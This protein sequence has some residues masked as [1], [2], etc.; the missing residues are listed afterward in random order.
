ML[1]HG[2][3]N[4]FI[5]WYWFVDSHGRR[6]AGPLNTAH[7]G[8]YHEA[9]VKMSSHEARRDTLKASSQLQRVTLLLWRMLL[10]ICIDPWMV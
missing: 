10:F 5:V 3:W 1:G 7:P 6:K 8:V 4:Q 9:K 2:E